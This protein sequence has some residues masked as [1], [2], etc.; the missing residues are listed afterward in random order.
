MRI[1]TVRVQATE[2][3]PQIEFVSPAGAGCGRW[4]S[5]PVVLQREYEVEL[6]FI[7]TYLW[8]ETA[9]LAGLEC[10][11]EKIEFS[12][13]Q[14]RVCA[15]AVDVDD[16]CVTLQLA[17]SIVLLELAGFPAAH[18]GDLIRFAAWPDLTVIT[19]CHT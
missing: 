11:A 12:G 14:N 6:D 7:Q 3:G 9:F 13:G 2:Q 10:T 18:I 15:R 8:G 17:G 1:R 16:S 19:D 4:C 5:G